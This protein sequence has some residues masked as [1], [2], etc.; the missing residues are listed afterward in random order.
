MK[1]IYTI[2]LVAFFAFESNAQIVTIPAPNFKLALTSTICADTNDDGILDGDV[3][4][5][6]DGQIQ[7]SE[8]LA[9]TNLS[10]GMYSVSSLVGI[11]SFTN[12]KS[13]GCAGVTIISISGLHQLKTLNVS[14]C[15]LYSLTLTD[16]DQLETL[17]C[18][19]NEILT[20]INYS[21]LTSLKNLNFAK[22]RMT[23]FDA[24]NL[25]AIENI[26][27]SENLLAYLTVAPSNNITDLKCSR[28][29]YLVVNF[30]TMPNLKTL[31]FNQSSLTAIDVSAL[32]QLE[33][34]DCSLNNIPAL[35][36][37]NL[38]ALKYLNCNQNN[39]TAL[40]L[41]NSTNLEEIHC[42]RNNIV[43]LDCSNLSILK[44]L[45][46]SENDLTSLNING[47]I[48]LETVDCN[49]N[50][51]TAFET[52][53]LTTLKD[54]NCSKNI[55]V[56]LPLENL[57][58]LKT[59]DCNTNALTS[60]NLSAL[61]NLE[62]L[63][64]SKNELASLDVGNLVNLKTLNCNTNHIPS[65]DA[66]NSIVLESLKCAVN[67]LTALNITPL[68]NLRTL[69]CSQNQIDSID[70]STNTKLIVIEVGY[71]LFTSLDFSHIG[72]GLYA[73]YRYY[74]SGNPNLT[75][76]NI[77]NGNHILHTSYQDPSGIQVHDCPN[78]AYVCA[79]ES[80]FGYFYETNASVNSYC[81]FTP[82]GTYN[83]IAGNFTLDYDNNGC[84]TNDNPFSYTK[85][86]INDGSTTGATFTKANGNYSFFTE[87]GDFTI[88]PTFENPYFTV[89]PESAVVNFATLDGSTF[90]QNF[91]VSPN[92]IHNDVEITI[93]PAGTAR[94]GFN[95]PYFL[96]FKNKGNQIISG[97]ISFTFNDAVMDLVSTEPAFDGQTSSTLS[98][99][100]QNLLPFESR[101]I[102]VL[103]NFNSPQEIP[104][105]NSGD[106]LDFSAT[107]NPVLGDETVADNTFELAQ[108]V[109]NSYDPNDKT[110]LEGDTVAPEKIGDYLHYVIRFQNSGT[111]AAQNIVV[112][113]VLD[114]EAYD[115][116]S[117]QLVGSSHP[118]TTRISGNKVE[119]IFEGINLPAEQDNEPASHGF[120]AFK[121]KTKNSVM[122][123]SSVS[124]KAEI[125]FDYNFPITTNTA[126]TLF[127][128]LSRDEFEDTSVS[129]YP[130][131][132]TN[133]LT[134]SAKDNIKS[135][136]LYDVMGRLIAT[137]LQNS[138]TV[139]FDL[140]QKAS[141]IY[142]VK[143]ATQKGNKVQKIIKE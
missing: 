137:D 39:L 67:E 7:V 82:G 8:A 19:E 123:G 89:S 88:A 35:G 75:Y 4:T 50:L 103:M 20:T 17:D 140:S 98:W 102:S 64:C 54:L 143:I 97:D 2:V 41:G 36:L 126:T 99:N 60:I 27:G 107:I 30:S 42:S 72:G 14:H 76:V 10:I 33:R 49:S 120:V 78:L 6:N 86:T 104:P 118:H 57:G 100:Y 74:M 3:D 133:Q 24:G 84:D 52:S 119:F 45:D 111:A 117:L 23:G 63:D 129:V 115:V 127:Q 47:A 90:T 135:I 128:L 16:L 38:A 29:P 25:P 92:G 108:I 121:I 83:T 61:S 134:V 93:V 116:D 132:V 71:N 32:T 130:N 113:D 28:N 91:C 43:G 136:Q 66:T 141:G 48:Q 12:L 70:F 112:A 69:S 22:C 81:S 13:L 124:N 110:C 73:H 26:N 55:L 85:I 51:L 139:H 5:N 131:P 65:L 96:E 106:V 56:S 138:T 9:V 77:K 101:V 94:P 44:Y 95:M 31:E 68:V 58:Q 122:A 142:F 37:S 114:T 40:D 53:N 87:T 80:S 15:G 21:G 105:L 125:F 18:S 79:D 109:S 46:C 34:L 62:T 59:L 1:K 11:N